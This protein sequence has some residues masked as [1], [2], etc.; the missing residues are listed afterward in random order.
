[1]RDDEWDSTF[2][3]V[4]TFCTKY[5]IMIPNIDDRFVALGRPQ[6]NSQ[7][8][9]NLH[10]FR[11]EL[12]YNIIDMQIQELND[13][14]NE[15][16]TDLLLCLACLSPVDSF[17][18]F[19]KRKLIHFADDEFMGL[20]GIGDLAQMMVHTRRN[21][22]YPLVYRLVTLSLLLPVVT[23]TVE[24]VFSAMNIVKNRL[25]NRMGDQLMNNILLVYIL[26]D[27]FSMVD[28]EPIMKR[29]QAMKKRRGRL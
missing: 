18:A 26:K 20:K 10:H 7:E 13:R 8:I 29:F 15:V 24:R 22:V 2:N 4:S 9:T 27:V 25:Q 23:A 6:R 3:Q 16:N 21:G 19:N 11:V 5:N 28:N 17:S 12:F 14:F 1:M